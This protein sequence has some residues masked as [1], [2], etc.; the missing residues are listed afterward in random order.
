MPMT[1]FTHRNPWSLFLILG[2]TLGVCFFLPFGGTQAFA[3]DPDSRLFEQTPNNPNPSVASNQPLALPEETPNPSPNLFVT[4][5]RLLGAL[6][7]IIALIV[8]TV[9]GLKLVWEKRGWNQLSDDGKP[10]RVLTSTYIAPRKAIHL[11][12]VGKRILVVG[13]GNEELNC[14]DIIQDPEE[15]EALKN[16]CIQGF[17]KILNKIVRRNESADQEAETEKIIKESNVAVGDYVEKLKKM[18]RRKNTSE[19]PDGTS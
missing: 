19:P 18:K 15:V 6:A 9:W 3:L 5:L 14:L 10:I 4:F 12:E 8:A 13:V 7:I 17:P 11:V 2:W 16:S 1:H